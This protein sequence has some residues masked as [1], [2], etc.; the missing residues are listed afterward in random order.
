LEETLSN[1]QLLKK[2]VYPRIETPEY[3][4]CLIIELRLM[5]KVGKTHGIETH[6]DSLYALLQIYE[7]EREWYSE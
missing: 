6:L 2:V 1:V 3:L 5:Q 7:K 4:T